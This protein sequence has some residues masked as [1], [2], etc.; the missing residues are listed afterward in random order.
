MA[1]CP[2]P[3]LAPVKG[4][5]WS[6]LLTSE[7]VRYGGMGSPPFSDEGHLKLPGQ[8]ALVLTSEETKT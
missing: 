6:V 5:K 7:H 8:T 3:L 2:E 1:P 4:N